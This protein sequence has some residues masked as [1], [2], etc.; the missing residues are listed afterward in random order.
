MGAHRSDAPHV[1][2]A[3]PRWALRTVILT[4]EIFTAVLAD[5]YQDLIPSPRMMTVSRC[6][7]AP[8]VVAV[9]STAIIA[10]R[11]GYGASA[12]LV[13]SS[14]QAGPIPIA[15]SMDPPL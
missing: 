10:G 6:A 1:Q 12:G 14:S 4:T 15:T 2:V 7:I 5:K 13:R 8:E 3:M 11:H 9:S